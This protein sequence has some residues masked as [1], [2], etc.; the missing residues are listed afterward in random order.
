MMMLET[1]V[2]DLMK[3]D[4]WRFLETISIL[5]KNLIIFLIQFGDHTIYMYINC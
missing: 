4:R 3:E 5:S 2:V 1:N